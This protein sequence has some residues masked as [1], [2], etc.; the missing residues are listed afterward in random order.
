I[1]IKVEVNA[2]VGVGQ[3]EPITHNIQ[4]NWSVRIPTSAQLK[5]PGAP[6]ASVTNLWLE[7]ARWRRVLLASAVRK[8]PV[9]ATVC[10]VVLIH[11]WGW[12][13]PRNAVGAVAIPPRTAWG[14]KTS[15]EV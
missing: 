2:T 10:T 7:I 5:A 8:V 15:S 12:C 11:R 4:K 14:H 1:A 3:R 6:V 13:C 9:P